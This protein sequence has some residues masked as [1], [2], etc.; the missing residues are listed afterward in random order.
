MTRNPHGLA[1]YPE[2]WRDGQPPRH[3]PQHHDPPGWPPAGPWPTYPPAP[4]HLSQDLVLMLGKI[5]ERTEATA[6]QTERIEARQI[7]IGQRLIRGDARF[8][9]I[10]MTIAE[11]LAQ[12]TPPPTPKSEPSPKPSIPW[13]EVVKIVIGATAL[14]GAAAGFVPWDHAL[15]LFGK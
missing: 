9:K 6:A 15:K 13:P 2:H 5:C 4:P 1:I 14:I 10:E 7:E 8:E 12:L 11:K 3:P